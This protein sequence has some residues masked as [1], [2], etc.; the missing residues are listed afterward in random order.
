MHALCLS[1][2]LFPLGV[3][4]DGLKPES[5]LSFSGFGTAGM[6]R[7]STGGAEF[8][9]DIL[10][11]HGVASGWSGNTDSR[12]G[13]QVSVRPTAEIEGVVQAVSYYNYASSYRPELTWAFVSYAPNPGWKARAGRLGW[14]VYMLSDSRNVGYSYLWVRPPVDY[15]GQLQISH[16]DGADVVVKHELGGGLA[17]AKLYGGRADQKVPSP[18]SPDYDL[19]GTRVV[20]A[21]LDYQKGEWLFRAGYTTVDIENELPAFVPLL[22]ALR[23]T[24]LPSAAALAAELSLADKT[25]EIV[26]LGAVYEHG[27]WQSQLMFNRLTS[28]T[29][30]YPRKDSGYFLLGYR[31]GQWTP[32]VTL[33]GTRSEAV[34]PR[35]T[36]LPTPNPLDSAVAASLAS[37][38]SR[39]RT[40]S[41]GVRYDF[42]RNMDLKIQIDQV[43]VIDNA[44]FLWRDP[45]PGWNGRATV[46]SI[47]LDFV[48]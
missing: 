45:Q 23:A 29:L 24:G 48:F 14:D 34:Q 43:R 2:F 1:A 5:A 38:Q 22:A 33:S 4:A 6:T 17:S 28:D 16:I 26:S 30:A 25:L 8:I 27:P 13:L 31:T 47:A 44:A 37:A 41:L 7:N 46:F 15:F 10:Q 9:R 39:Q 21:N 18:P 3:H 12:L 20:G 42:M 40:L 32:F 11:P 19:A 35:G 36:G